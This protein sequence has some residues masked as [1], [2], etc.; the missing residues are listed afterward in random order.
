[1][2][3]DDR[4]LPLTRGQ[5][6]IWL[7][8]E[9]GY[10]GT[11]WQL[12]LFVRIEG[13][14]QRDA[15][16]WAIR[17]V[18]Q[19]AEPARAAFV[20]MDG[21]VFQRAIDCSDVE[22][23]FYDL[24]DMS[25][26]VQEAR[27]IASSIQ[28]T[29]M[30]FAG[31]LFRFALFRTRV[32]EFHLFACCHHIVVDGTGVALIGH[33]IASVY[34]AIVS[35]A[36]VPGTVFGSLRDLVDCE[37]AYEASD[38]YRDDEAYWTQNLPAEST[39]RRVSHVAGE[40]T[41]WP[42]APVRLDP[43]I[44][45]RVDELSLVWHTSRTSVITAACAFL[46]RGWCAD[47]AEVVL[48]FPVS[49]RVRPESKTL[50][51]MVAGAVPLVLSVSPN[52]TVTDFC[53]QVDTRIR[54]ALRHQ[55]FPVHA[56]ERKTRG[57]GR[58]ADRVSVNFIPAGFTLPFGGVMASA[59][60]TNSGQVGGFGLIFSSDGDQLFLST[61]GVGGPLS[62]F[63]VGDLA[64]RLQQALVAM[65]ADPVRRLSTI[66]V[67]DAG[68]YA[69]LTE[70]G[71]RA[72]LARP[73]APVSI[74]AL[75]AAQVERT[76]EAVAISWAGRSWTYR[77]VEESANRLAHL[78]ADRGV[79][80][81]A[82]VGLLLPRSAQAVVAIVAVL[83]TGAAY[84]P[85]DP[86][87]PDARIG[88]MLADAAPLAV[89]TTSDRRARLGGS[90]VAVVDVDDPA[91]DC[92]PDSPLPTPDP[93]LIAHLIYTSGTTGIPKGV[94]VTH[95]N[96]T[97]LFD[98]L[99]VGLE[100]GPGQVWSQC[101]SLAFDFSVWEIWGALLHGGRLVVVPE[102]VT[103]SPDDL[104]ALLIAERVS[105]LT[106]TPSAVGM[107]SPQG[108]GSAALVIG[109]EACPVEVVDRWAPGRVMVN[110]Y[111]P[112]E[113][114]MWASKSAPLS[115]GSGVPPIGSPV[116]NA[117]F[118]V[119]DGWL[120]PVPAGVVGELY[121][122]G[123]GV[124]CG[125]VRRASLTASRFVACPGGA[126]GT[127]MYRTGDLVCWGADGQLQYLG[128]A[129][130]QVK[131]RG[132]RIELGEVQA[133][134]AGLDGVRQAAVTAREDRPGDKRLVAYV[135]GSADPA[136]ARTVLTERLPAYMVPAAVV[137]LEAL[138]LTVNGKLDTQALPVPEYQD[139]DRYRAP[140]TVVEELLAGI[141]AQVL[142]VDR[143]GV[144]DSFFSLG[145]DSLS[146]MRLVAAVNAS[147]DAHL[148]VRT[149]F[150][151]PSVALLAAHVGGGGGRLARVVAGARPAVVPLSFA[152]S[153]LWFL[154]QL[155]GPS[156]VHNMAVALQL[157]GRLDADALGAAFGDV[158][159]RHESL[160]TLFVAPDGKP[161]QVVIPVERADLGWQVIDASAWPASRLGEAIDAV[162]AHR[163]DLSAEIPLRAHLFRL[164]DD[165]HV[166]VAV[167]HHIAADGWSI[168]PLVRD[169]GI[170]YASRCAGQAPD[171]AP[172]AVQYVD[173]T[174]WQRTQFG[175]LQDP[176]SPI[177]G[178]LRYWQDALAGMPERLELPTDRPYSLVADH[179]GARVAVQWPAE[180][181]QRVREVAG[182]H[183]ATSFMVVQAALAV[184]L[185]ALSG[186]GDVAV[187]FPIAGRGDPA[188]DELVGF[189]V[190][191]LVLRVDL[192]GDPSV[193]E[194]L[195]QVRQR[196][197]AAY[198]HQDVPF[199]VL[200]ERLH[201]TRS[202]AHH[203]LVQVVLAWQNLPWQHNGPTAGLALGDVQVTPMPVDTQVARM[204]VVLSLAEHWTEAGE[205]AGIGG[206][207]EFRTDV[208]DAASIEAL[209]ER[210]GRV[211]VAVTADPTRRLSSI[212]VLDPEECGRLDDIGNR[213]AL[214]R[215][216]RP[217]VSIPELWAAQVARTPE[218]V[219]LTCNG[220]SMTYRGVEEAANRLAHLLIGQGVGPGACVGLLSERSAQAVVA[221]VA[222]LKTGA[223]YLP[224]DPGLP[225]TRIA[226]MLNDSAPLA[227]F[228]TAQ[229]RSRLDGCDVRVIDLHDP[230]VDTQPATG[231]PMPAA[232]DVAHIIYTSGTTG[233][234]KG[235]A[236]T[237]HNVT[238]LFA[239]LD[240]QLGLGPDQVWSQCHSLAFDFSVWEIWGA[241]LHGGRL[242]VVPDATVRSPDDLRAFLVAERVSVLS[243]T[244]SAFYALQQAS[245]QDLELQT[246]VFGGEAL[247]PQ[248][249]ETWLRD[250][251]RLPRLINMYGITETTVHA[252]FREIVDGDV[253]S[254][255]SPIGVPLAHLAFFVLDG[256]L[257]AV[258][259]G[260]VGELYVAGAGVGCGYVRRASLTA[261]RFVAC[262]FAGAGARMYRTG[263]LVRW[264][265]DGQLQYLGR[266]DEQ[267]KVRGYRVE[268][269]EIRAALAGL[270][271][272]QRAVVLAR[273]DRPGDRRLVGYVTGTADAADIR[274][275]LAERLPG[276]MVPAAVVVLEALPLTVNGKLDTQALPMPEYQDVDRYRAPDSLTEE[277]LAG[278]YAQVLGLERVGVDDSFFDLGGDSLLA[279]R[280]V[281]AINT[282]FAAG[283]SVRVV[284]EAPTVA[285]LAARVGGGGG[286]L[287][288][289][290]GGGAAGGGAV[291]VCAV[292]V[293][294]CGAVAGSVAGVQRGGC[295]AVGWGAG[296]RRVGGG[297]G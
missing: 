38:D 212:D 242:V 106:Q 23:A 209:I 258:P 158:V 35:G 255:V 111:G 6:D 135:T 99:D 169:L 288:R 129:D 253:A 172:L 9:T 131:V 165:E 109:A 235:V 167:A 104:Q 149:V 216:A 8:Q 7:A 265:V 34:S 143:V 130:E 127:R 119:L 182:E 237:H 31:P 213:A 272:V 87:L 146:A 191:T 79:G 77:E 20:E 12:G 205:P 96:V 11:E 246:V 267:V 126:P 24:S 186:S 17:R 229:L 85:I 140:T 48:D 264:G 40:R 54:E 270:D 234:P 67:L 33:R 199:E 289:V 243:Q 280:L 202:L 196:S 64:R 16:Q 108:V 251:P 76:P 292:A 221:I 190:N 62:E 39:G 245:S 273:E 256:W 92:R 32:D 207:V 93:D 107:L 232:E 95:R 148:A 69:R 66:D 94:A 189:F 112:T 181:Q 68:D 248:R 73:A 72:V 42:S 132:Y 160:R 223:A 175:E 55:R 122:A 137:V 162:A 30:P 260:V 283:V 157:R 276:Y 75:F 53:R 152:Q 47:G 171:W 261:S 14:V 28:R 188:L 271:G 36:P 164:G 74:P 286:G 57:P 83:K 100:L 110:V 225:T 71:N 266:A 22:L 192:A 101:H 118:L 174:L 97:Q 236:V 153:R 41:P 50:P 70:W 86:G 206:A 58:P 133:A 197:L 43:G 116:A 257:R 262:P 290:V 154:D 295:V 155:H 84:L 230:V 269:G 224:I 279:M 244:P 249:L 284:F 80:P 56:L 52:C 259:V 180:L 121:V 187:G 147:M 45:G 194:L 241:L 184:L 2:E 102:P 291:V 204:D 134:V 1:M 166:L 185:S 252:S 65:T 29:P 219:A 278:I 98:S 263:D 117:A 125:Y 26:P 151:A 59:S 193:A 89:I 156:A 239:S 159:A 120:R 178:Q 61:A 18:V 233:V 274:S 144:D 275:A 200:V 250:H 5:L 168:T 173:Y 44:L 177:A 282:S 220:R 203:P 88:F 114:T 103:R 170:A 161:Q 145:G 4:A 60:Y 247:E 218:A 296:R 139:I 21:E 215:P 163:F 63:D 217:G 228:A 227:V 37:S 254:N 183:N 136:G 231:L 105:V 179:R 51:G 293:V 90:P 208:F 91:V 142:G 240:A 123:A 210:L 113:T 277:V 82:C 141:Y 128:R 294:V 150:D 10:A 13:T 281:A 27:A 201:P 238:Q 198:E 25:D 285:L 211:L 222:V 115:A 268:L 138:P 19:E 15:L 287:A 176:D 226:F 46:V 214:T 78:L 81:G 49:R 297:A 3:L 195:D 124:G